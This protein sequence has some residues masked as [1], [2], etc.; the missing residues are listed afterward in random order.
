MVDVG[1]A[2]VITSVT[3][4]LGFSVF[5]LSVMQSQVLFGVLL[6]VTIVVAL[7]ADFFLMPALILTFEPFGPETAEAGSVAPAANAGTREKRSWK[8]AS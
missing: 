4:V 6:S 5:L 7:I 2:L 1:R 8:K 3:L